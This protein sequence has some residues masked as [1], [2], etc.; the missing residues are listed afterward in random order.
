MNVLTAVFQMSA[1]WGQK[2]LFSIISN[3]LFNSPKRCLCYEI[4]RIMLLA[5]KIYVTG[6]NLGVHGNGVIT[7]RFSEESRVPSGTD[8]YLVY[9]FAI[10]LELSSV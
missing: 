5:T 8:T 2:A 3:I 1:V 7:T 9:R 6:Y 4:R 10:R